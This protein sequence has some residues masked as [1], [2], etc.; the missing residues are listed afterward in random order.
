[1]SDIERVAAVL[2]EA[3]RARSAVGPVSDLVDGGLTLDLAHAICEANVERRL[4]A[5]ERVAGFKVGFTNIPAR[6]KIRRPATYGYLFDSMVL[7]S[8]GDLAM[9]EMIAP[10]IESEICFRLGRDLAGAGLTVEQ[11]LEATEA[12]SASFEIC[13]ARIRDWKCPYPDFFADN[14]FSARIVLSGRW[15]PV[16]DV[17]IL[18]EAVSLA[19]DGVPFADGGGEMALGN[20]A[21]AVAWLAG[22]LAERGRG[23]S[24]GMVVMTGTFTPIT[25]IE[26]GSTYVASFSTLG[27]VIKTFV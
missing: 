14:G 27:S 12:V 1:V 2:V 17:D 22:K 19:K 21:N 6:E 15:V 3:E 13:D 16:G 18:G 23:L 24:A 9:A 5:G 25:S 8:G 10:K 26:R 11:V 7:P 4:A 20:P